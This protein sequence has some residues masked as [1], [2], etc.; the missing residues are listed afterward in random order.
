MIET[1]WEIEE[2]FQLPK[3]INVNCEFTHIGRHVLASQGKHYDLGWL[4][5]YDSSKEWKAGPSSINP[6][7]VDNPQLA[8]ERIQLTGLFGD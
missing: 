5:E 7:A 2:G 6:T 3:A 1:T 8:K 4:R